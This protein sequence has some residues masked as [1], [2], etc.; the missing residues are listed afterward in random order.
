MM[1]PLRLASTV[2]SGRRVPVGRPRLSNV[3]VNWTVLASFAVGLGTLTS[4][5]VP[6][7]R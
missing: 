6:S 4:A 2:W 3:Y 1:A 7:V 5:S